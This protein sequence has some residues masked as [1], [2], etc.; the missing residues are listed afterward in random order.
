MFLLLK[1]SQDK[2]EQKYFIVL[3]G[4]T[5][6]TRPWIRFVDCII[7]LRGIV[8]LPVIWPRMSRLR[9]LFY[10]GLKHNLQWNMCK[11]KRKQQHSTAI[12]VLQ[13]KSKCLLILF[14]FLASFSVGS[15][16]SQR[17]TWVAVHHRVIIH[18]FVSCQPAVYSKTLIVTYMLRDTIVKILRI[19]ASEKELYFTTSVLSPKYHSNPKHPN[20]SWNCSYQDQKSKIL[21]TQ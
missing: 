11:I 19:L 18:A 13:I 17:E 9:T 10:I 16:W 8:C 15:C 14:L 20:P 21:F 2:T 5:K 12:F 3:E 4:R 6:Q 1:K 7:S